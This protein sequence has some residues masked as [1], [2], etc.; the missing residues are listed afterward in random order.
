MKSRIMRKLFFGDLLI[1]LLLLLLQLNFQTFLFE[2]FLVHEQS[3]RLNRSMDELQAAIVNGDSKLARKYIDA[4]IERGIVMV[5]EDAQH[6]QVFGQTIYQYQRCFVL[7][8]NNGKAYTIVED[9]L[10]SI[11]LQT[12]EAGDEISVDGYLIDDNHSL[13]MPSKVYRPKDG[14][15]LGV[16]TLLIVEPTKESSVSQPIQALS[17]THNDMEYAPNGTMGNRDI[18]LPSSDEHSSGRGVA[19]C[20]VAVS[21]ADNSVLSAPAISLQTEEST[22]CSAFPPDTAKVASNDKSA[23]ISADE[24]SP[25]TG[26]VLHFP[27][28]ILNDSSATSQSSLPMNGEN[29]STMR[30]ARIMIIDNNNRSGESFPISITGRVTGTNRIEDQDLIIQQGLINKEFERLS[31]RSVMAESPES[32]THNSKMT[33]G[34]YFLR[35]VQIAEPKMTLIGAISLYSIKDMNNMM[36]T[37]HILLFITEL[38]L[39]IIAIYFFSRTIAKPLVAMNDI[40]L[41]IAHQDFSGKV[42]VTTQDEIGSLAQSINTISSNLEQTIIEINA[43]HRQLQL[44]YERQVALQN[45]HKELSATFSHELKTPLTIIRACIDSI[46][47]SNDPVKL[48]EYNTIALRE[49][50]LAGNLITQM[51]E[52]ARMES[53]YFALEK[54][55]IDLWMV[56]YKV[57]DDLR[58]TIEQQGMHVVYNVGDEAF[59]YADAELLERVIANAMTNAMKYSPP[60]SII[61]IAISSDENQNIFKVVN[62]NSYILPEDMERIW[63]PFYRGGKTKTDCTKGSGLGL[64]IVSTILKAH[65]FRYTL[66]NTDKG[67][68]FSFS[69]PV[70]ESPTVFLC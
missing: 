27:D 16:D 50:D 47:S 41:R 32:Y 37:F 6:D 11:Y 42:N 10:D 68:E 3:R 4:G 20:G 57:Y 53:P 22:M 35:V 7:E 58:Q 15:V 5:A 59:V 24:D 54:R 48:V 69:C 28:D 29:N 2:P 49:L 51:L 65:G 30:T 34:E 70:S 62:S 13:V 39:V 64:V 33:T 63:K 23:A 52:I 36:N 45:R 21:T 46:Q 44:D 17:G 18:K 19:S 14:I 56:F 61:T 1:F 25:S 40:A 60:G 38:I 8:D 26:I 67:V 31:S 43:N 66:R 9:Y 12:M 55:V